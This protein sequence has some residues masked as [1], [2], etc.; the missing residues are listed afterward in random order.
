M[1]QSDFIKLCSASGLI[2][3][4]SS[5]YDGAGW[6]SI[7]EFPFNNEV[8]SLNTLDDQPIQCLV[9]IKATDGKRKSV[10]VKL[11][12][13]K[14]FCDSPL[15]CFFFFANYDGGINITTAYLVHIDKDIMFNTL[16][17]IR[18]ND[19]GDKKPLNQIKIPIKYSEKDIISVDDAESLKKAIERNVPY[20][21]N[22][23][24]INKLA[25]LKELGYEGARFGAAFK[26]A[27][28]EDY[29]SLVKASLG[30]PT[31]VRI[32]DIKGWDNRFDLKLAVEELS[33]SEATIKITSVDAIMQGTVTFEDDKEDVSFECEG[34]ASPIAWDAPP[35]L[36][37]YR[38][39]TRCF[40]MQVGFKNNIT[41]LVFTS[42]DELVDIAELR[43]TILLMKLLNAPKGTLRITLE[44]NTGEKLHYTTSNSSFK[45]SQSA[46]A[47]IKLEKT[48]LAL[49]QITSYFRIN[50]N[51]KTSFNELVKKQQDID[52]M[53]ALIS[54]RENE[55]Q[56][57]SVK[58]DPCDISFDTDKE[59]HIF[60]V[61]PLNFSAFSICLAFIAAGAFTQHND[62]ISLTPYKTI[63]E[64]AIKGDS[65][66]AINSK[67]Q[68]I[69]ESVT[70]RYE[71]EDKDVY[72][73]N[74]FSK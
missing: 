20:G 36:A 51:R 49:L 63:I 12:N 19:V 18:Q 31:Q 13:M 40:D 24:C 45:D 26:V 54:D 62:R 37:M 60:I 69:S 7:V 55:R 43:D 67:V 29:N 14:R 39:K 3:N 21:L 68:E 34:Y 2:C 23:Y 70:K 28:E 48:A 50:K 10:Q 57:L 42:F 56:L 72:F 30:Y 52:S 74:S 38:I 9:Q 25:L 33:R 44:N 11:S 17:E 61:T 22:K 16:K 47:M 46:N 73:L 59:F 4:T 32:K 64:K 1:G 66:E 53:Y 5:N 58:F 27:T 6:D 8:S 65:K 71:N 41:N 15:P 35:E